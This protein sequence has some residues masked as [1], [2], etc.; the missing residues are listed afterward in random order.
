MNHFH[1][2]I[3]FKTGGKEGFP[4][5]ASAKGWVSRI[6]IS[7]TGFGNVV[8][9]DH[10]QGYTS[11]YAHL[12][13]FNDEL[14][15]YLDSARYASESSEVELFPDSGRFIFNQGAI[16]GRSGNTGSSEAPHL[17][18]E[19]RDRNSQVPINPLLFLSGFM[20]SIPPK[21]ELICLYR[22]IEGHFIQTGQLIL[23]QIPDSTLKIIVPYDSLYLGML[24][25]DPEGSS[26]LGIY[27]AELKYN[28]SIIYNF[29]F[30]RFSF[31]ETRYVNAHIDLV[32]TETGKKRIHRLYKLPAD[33]C[34]IFSNS[35][36]GLIQI[37]DSVV[38]NIKINLKDYMG[39]NTVILAEVF[40]Q[41]ETVYEPPLQP[42]DLIRVG[43]A[44]EKELDTGFKVIL[45]ATALYQNEFYYHHEPVKSDNYLSDIFP[46][47]PEMPLP[48]HMSGTLQIPYPSGYKPEKNKVLILRLDDKNTVKESILPDS[49]SEDF[50][51]GKFRSGG[52]Y[53]VSCDTLPPV[54]YRC[55]EAVDSVDMKNY[56][57]CSIKD[58][59]SGIKSIRVEID[60]RFSPAY[61][62]PK[63]QII[64]WLK[65]NRQVGPHWVSLELSDR[66]NNKFKIEFAE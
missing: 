7:F 17:H 52:Y 45:P 1:S 51:I 44:W 9:L 53:V 64:K 37:P 26:M 29:N 13:H 27:A 33:S 46:V 61:Y 14:S 57:Y 3:D 58:D 34:S 35:G 18:F 19:I 10:E 65:D 49:I 11:V 66:C 23:P 16:L 59:I 30:D 47:L 39:N 43:I 55:F 36:K 15:T 42:D 2:G 38:Q 50:I 24:C 22:L 62:D 5:Y 4:V 25:H 12:H 20:D 21:A 6:K 63:K 28:D 41:K 40:H 31:D 8:Y 48:L 32:Q 54:M 60:H 56:S